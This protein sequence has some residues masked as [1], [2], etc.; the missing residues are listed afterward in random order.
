MVHFTFN[1][2]HNNKYNKI[3]T[4]KCAIKYTNSLLIFIDSKVD[5]R[6]KTNSI[7]HYFKQNIK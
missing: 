4:Y 3:R 6:F 1:S 5:F 2:F 7:L